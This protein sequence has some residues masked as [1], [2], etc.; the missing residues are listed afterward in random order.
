MKRLIANSVPS[1][2]QLTNPVAL[3]H[4][5][6]LGEQQGVFHGWEKKL[7]EHIVFKSASNHNDFEKI[8]EIMNK[9]DVKK[10]CVKKAVH[11]STMAKDS[12]GVF[13]DSHEKEKIINLVDYLTLRKN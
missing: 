2:A 13:S 6:S 5:L 4:S 7:I 10:D 3:H 12:L 1:T 8:V 9:Y 11:F